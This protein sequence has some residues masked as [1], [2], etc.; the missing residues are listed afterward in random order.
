[1]VVPAVTDRKKERKG[2]DGGERREVKSASL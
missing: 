1:M 2:K